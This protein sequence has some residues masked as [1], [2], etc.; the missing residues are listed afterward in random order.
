MHTYTNLFKHGNMQLLI[1]LT[2][3]LVLFAFLIG[4]VSVITIHTFIT[5]DS[6]LHHCLCIEFQQE[7]FTACDSCPMRQW[8]AKKHTGNSGWWRGYT[9]GRT[10]F[11]AATIIHQNTWLGL[12]GMLSFLS[13]RVSV[14]STLV[15]SFQVTLLKVRG[16]ALK[17]LAAQ[18]IVVGSPFSDSSLN[19]SCMAIDNYNTLSR[20]HFE[21]IW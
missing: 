10:R 14:K 4:T 8:V 20:M 18:R 7:I 17:M 5:N 15:E 19:L 9:R 1:A 2:C 13:H 11:L 3:A 12:L 21:I 6:G 16:N